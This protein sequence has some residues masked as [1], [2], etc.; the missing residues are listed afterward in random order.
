MNRFATALR[1]LTRLPFP[2]RGEFAEGDLARSMAY[3][4][5]VGLIIGGLSFAAYALTSLVLPAPV[6]VLVLLA[7]PWVLSGGLHADGLTDFCDGFFG[8]HDKDSTLRIMKDSRIGTFGALGLV[9]L[10][11]SKYELLTC[12]HQKAPIF[13]LAMA[14][15]RWGQVLL[16]YFLP[17]AGQGEGLGGQVAGKVK[18]LEVW[19]AALVILPVIYWTGIPGVFALAVWGIFLVSFGFYSKRKIGGL[20]GDVIGAASELSEVVILLGGLMAQRIF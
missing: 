8:G 16:S 3:F 13:F 4:P 14:V 11:L 1:F 10:I 5:L 15:S 12:L 18:G 19:G 9:L 20:T 2:F 17:Y 7:A 6:A